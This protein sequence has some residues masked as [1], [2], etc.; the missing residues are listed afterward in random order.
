MEQTCG[1]V[2]DSTVAVGD[3]VSSIAGG[4]ADVAASCCAASRWRASFVLCMK[5]ENDAPT[6]AACAVGDAGMLE[7][8]RI[9]IVGVD[10]EAGWLLVARLKREASFVD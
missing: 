6:L 9:P 2:V 1:G 5:A 8:P 4:D 7:A 10:G 3:V